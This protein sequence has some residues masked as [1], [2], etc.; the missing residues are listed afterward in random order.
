MRT[1][2][3]IQADID[4]VLAQA[5]IGDQVVRN[6][7]GSE[8]QS[9]SEGE[10]RSVVVC[11]FESLGRSQLIWPLRPSGA[12]VRDNAARLHLAFRRIGLETKRH[13]HSTAPVPVDGAEGVTMR[14]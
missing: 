12:S 4:V 6:A 3:Q 11:R 5:A 2:E 7:D 14:C 9:R 13:Q 8:V 10:S 1:I